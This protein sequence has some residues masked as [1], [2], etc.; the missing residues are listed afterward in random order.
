MVFA[1]RDIVSNQWAGLA[2]SPT[3][4]F[5]K[6]L[7]GIYTAY[8]CPIMQGVVLRNV[9]WVYLDVFDVWY[10]ARH[11]IWAIIG[12]KMVPKCPQNPSSS[13]GCSTAKISCEK[14]REIAHT[15]IKWVYVWYTMLNFSSRPSICAK[16]QSDWILDVHI[17]SVWKTS[18]LYQKR[19][20]IRRFSS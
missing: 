19:D 5:G 6:I 8:V 14:A 11:H 17:M 2:H 13:K 12:P 7:C 10:D 3:P 1:A 18:N 9:W 20:E 16:I 15:M 4:I